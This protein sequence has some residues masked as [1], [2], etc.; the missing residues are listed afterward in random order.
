MLYQ[1]I[2]NLT[3]YDECI[4]KQEPANRLK[5][6]AVTVYTRTCPLPRIKIQLYCDEVY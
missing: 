3:T 6:L 5:G 2:S 1:V 4:I